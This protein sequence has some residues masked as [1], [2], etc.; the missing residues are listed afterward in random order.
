MTGRLCRSARVSRVWYFMKRKKAI[1]T[2]AIRLLA[3]AL[4]AAILC[5]ASCSAEK[6]DAGSAFDSHKTGS[7]E[8]QYAEQFHVDYY[9][10]DVKAVSIEDG[11]S[12]LLVPGGPDDA[13]PEWLTEENTADFTVIRTPANKA[14]IAASSAMD[15]ISALGCL[16]NVSMTSTQATDWALPEIKELVEKDEIHY[17]GKYRSPDYEALVEDD[18][19]IAV[20]STMIY[21][22]PQVKEAI[23]ELGIPVLVER[24]S[25]ENDPLGRLEWIK[26]YG[27]L[28]GMEDEADE[29][30]AAA[31]DKINSF[32]TAAI[33]TVPDVAFFSVNSAGAV[34]VRKPG[35]Y[36]T[37]M[38]EMAG[39][40][41][42]LDGLDT[43][44]EDNALSTMNMQM[45]AFY[46]M[47]LDSDILIYNSAI[48]S[49]LNTID[50]LTALSDQFADYK[51]VKDGNVWCTN[52][53]MFQKTTGAADMIVEMNRI[54]AGAKDDS[55][56]E[57][58]HKL[59]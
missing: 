47:A 19:D 26:L 4:A 44:D 38:I 34:V 5:L 40:Q 24:S 36:V 41:Y 35:D 25:Y 7:M 20:E 53:S 32:D 9:D 45:E 57:Y 18:I 52:K 51:A 17:I 39:G 37:K 3:A 13:M 56:M 58:F 59:D 14:Y 54:F 28:F 22:N 10:D 49:D 27:L 2:R 12:Y 8:L 16:G 15:L 55:G 31:E 29:F 23:E 1:K 21:H 48:E 50:D 46:D 33:E 11:L 43:D 30:F 42:V 6:A